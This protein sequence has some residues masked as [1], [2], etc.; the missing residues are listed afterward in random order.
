MKVI[1]EDKHIYWDNDEK[2]WYFDNSDD[3]EKQQSLSDYTKQVRKEVCD[4][5]REKFKE[6]IFD[7]STIDVILDKIQGK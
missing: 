6:I 5:I 7:S 3:Y 2:K 4:E 1:V